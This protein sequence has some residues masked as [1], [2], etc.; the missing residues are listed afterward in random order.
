MPLRYT[1]RLKK[2]E[3]ALWELTEPEDFFLN[4][5]QL[6]KEEQIFLKNLPFGKSNKRR[7]EWLAAR[8]LL[9]LLDDTNPR[10]SLTYLPSGQPTFAQGP[11]YCSLSHSGKWIAAANSSQPIGIDVQII[12]KRILRLS[13]KFM[14]QQEYNSWATNKQKEKIYTLYWAAKEALYK[15]TELQAVDFKKQLLIQPNQIKET[16]SISAK[17]L[18]ANGILHASRTLWYRFF[19]NFVYCITC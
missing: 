14:T 11:G 9:Q 7:R 6:S 1:H 19:E 5:L 17:V 4:R 3:A 12:E 2:G 18:Q 15:T 13:A 16:G 8:H 10:R